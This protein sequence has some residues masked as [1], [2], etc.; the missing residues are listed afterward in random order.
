MQPAKTEPPPRAAVTGRVIVVKGKTGNPEYALERAR[1]NI[2]RLVELTDA[3]HR[4]VRR[5]E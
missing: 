2:G 1:T 4:V 3:D 5:N